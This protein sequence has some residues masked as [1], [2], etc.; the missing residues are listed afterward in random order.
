MG[1][2]PHPRNT[3]WHWVKSEFPIWWEDGPPTSYEHLWPARGWC[4]RKWVWRIRGAWRSNPPRLPNMVQTRLFIKGQL[5]ARVPRGAGGEEGAEPVLVAAGVHLLL[6]ASG[7]SEMSLWF[8]APKAHL[9]VG[10]RRLEGLGLTVAPTTPGPS[11]TC[12]PS[13]PCWELPPDFPH[14]PGQPGLCSE[15]GV[16]LWEATG[17]RE[18]RHPLPWDDPWKKPDSGGHGARLGKSVET[19]CR[20]MV[21]RI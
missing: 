9:G 7:A 10:R 1:T 18:H 5:L 21:A 3:G 15:E 14:P 11:P 19:E 2:A 6:P 4:R 13:P 12:V 17:G 8:P 16:R 20:P